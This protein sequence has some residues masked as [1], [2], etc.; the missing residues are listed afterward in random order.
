MSRWDSSQQLRANFSSFDADGWT[1]DWDEQYAA[2]V[3][4]AVSIGLQYASAT[5]KEAFSLAADAGYDSQQTMAL[6]S[7]ATLASQTNLSAL[8][9]A[10]A[11]HGLSFVLLEDAQPAPRQ[12]IGTHMALPHAAGTSSTYGA[13]LAASVVLARQDGL[14]LSDQFDLRAAG[15]LGHMA[16]LAQTGRLNM[17]DTITLAQQAGISLSLTLML[18]AALSLAV[19]N[20]V[21]TG[22]QLA[23]PASVTLSADAGDNAAA[24][25]GLVAGVTLA[26]QPISQAGQVKAISLQVDMAALQALA[27]LDQLK[28]EDQADF[29][30]SLA[31][32][33]VAFMHHTASEGRTLT[34][35]G[36]NRTLRLT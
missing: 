12:I 36:H 14:V 15:L 24:Q 22:G 30:A 18:R 34:I 4:R 7:A 21:A 9:A 25:A 11:D 3:Y 29:A 28:I 17:A 13:G 5:Y 31:D 23:M 8:N 26:M 16:T 33:L 20:V 19:E 6:V 32:A 1:L 27:V 2:S 35:P 10:F